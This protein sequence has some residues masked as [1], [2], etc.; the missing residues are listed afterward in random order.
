MGFCA[1]YLSFSFNP[2]KT[3]NLFE[4]SK[5]S[6][7]ESETYENFILDQTLTYIDTKRHG[8]FKPTDFPR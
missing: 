3:D 6:F 1:E 5:S 7:V 8:E 2:I 4:P